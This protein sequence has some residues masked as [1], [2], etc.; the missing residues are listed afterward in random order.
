MALSV[1]SVR[2]FTKC[3]KNSMKKKTNMILITA[4]ISISTGQQALSAINSTGQRKKP[5]YN[6]LDK[7]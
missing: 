6:Y 4:V 5:R 1:I 7:Q 3:K 2:W